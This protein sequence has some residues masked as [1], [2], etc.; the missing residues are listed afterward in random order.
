MKPEPLGVVFKSKS[1]TGKLTDHW[2]RVAR[3]D[4]GKLASNFPEIKPLCRLV[5]ING[6]PAPATF[7]AAVPMPTALDVRS[8]DDGRTTHDCHCSSAGQA[9]GR[10]T[11]ENRQAAATPVK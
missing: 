10:R 8:L 7:K 11:A 1:A 3:V 9:E 4:P 2:P 6:E 5:T